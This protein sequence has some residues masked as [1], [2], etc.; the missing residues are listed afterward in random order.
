MQRNILQ[1]LKMTITDNVVYELKI[2][3]PFK[4]L[5]QGEQ[6]VLSPHSMSHNLAGTLL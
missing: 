1:K 4:I 3:Q 2:A 5:S 6:I